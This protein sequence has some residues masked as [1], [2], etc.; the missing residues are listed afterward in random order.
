MARIPTVEESLAEPIKPEVGR[1]A[2]MRNLQW[3]IGGVVVALALVGV[4]SSS[5]TNQ[6]QDQ[7]KLA[8]K[9][10]QERLKQS[11][12][13]TPVNPEEVEKAIN[14]QKGRAENLQ[15]QDQ[16]M[17]PGSLAG[18][19]NAPKP[20]GGGQNQPAG[21][22]K[23]LVPPLP[24]VPGA[25]KSYPGITPAAPNDSELKA[26]E[27]S[28]AIK[29]EEQMRAAPIM[30]ITDT[31]VGARAQQNNSGPAPVGAGTMTPQNG[32]PM[33]AWNNQLEDAQSRLAKA[34]AGG[35]QEELLRNMQAAQ[36]QQV[37]GAQNRT[38]TYGVG[39]Q[40]ADTNSRWLDSQGKTSN[41]K[42]LT[43]E[44]PASQYIVGQGAV[45]PAVLI[46]EINSDM[47]GQLTAVV[48]MDVYDSINGDQL[49]IPKGAR[50]VGLYNNDV[51]AGQERVLAA[52]QRLVLPNGYS[53]DLM[54]MS[55]ADAQ[56][57]GGLPGEVDNHFLKM[58]GASIMTAGLA[59]LFQRNTTNNTVV[60]GGTSGNPG[61]TAAGQILV[62]LSK[63]VNDR[64]TRIP[65]TITIK[66]GHKFNVIVNKDIALTPYRS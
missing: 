49:M 33:T 1:S 55:S 30:A 37:G 58:F 31:G 2:K 18:T 25:T 29:R 38:G 48:S 7:T 59:Q 50:L 63:T 36:S 56:G 61:V 4:F 20:Y 66:Q 62:D 64:N 42:T 51:R 46:T 12:I 57:R 9:E 40:S 26:R 32:S 14:D 23:A 11:Q 3:I 43:A 52:F 15:P 54:G 19:T 53:V 21:A 5:T 65:P 39:N 44:R 16:D 6:E 35:P 8:E 60:V 47:P 27:A 24:N 41:A 10:R 28:D 22:D 17:I 34:R 13:G 45:I